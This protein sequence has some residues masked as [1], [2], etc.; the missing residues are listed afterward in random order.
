MIRPKRILVLAPHT[1][2]AELGCGGTMA[3]MLAEGAQIHVAVFS[4]ARA[5]LPHGAPPDILKDEFY[6]AMASM[7]VFQ[8]DLTVHDYPVRQLS[9]HR[10]EVLECLVTLRHKVRPE[11]VF[12]PAGTDLHQ[13]HQVVNVEGLRAFKDLTVWGY[14]LPWNHIEFAANAFVVLEESHLRKKWEVLQIYKTQMD[15]ARCYFSWEFVQS[16]ARIRGVQVKATYA[17][18]FEVMRLRM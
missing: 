5:S 14:E 12:L 10:Q 6:K 16:L 7:G 8:V 3:R 2:D 4:T 11:I 13:D 9:Y 17:E 15:L 1:D 18:A